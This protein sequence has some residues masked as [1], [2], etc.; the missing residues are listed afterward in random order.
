VCEPYVTRRSV[1][2]F[3]AREP[4]VYFFFSNRNY[5]N[6]VT[7]RPFEPLRGRLPPRTCR[8]RVQTI[9]SSVGGYD[10]CSGSCL[11]DSVS[12]PSRNVV[13]HDDEIAFIL[14]SR[15]DLDLTDVSMCLDDRQSFP[16]VFATERSNVATTRHY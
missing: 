12:R 16:N 3:F 9:P 4:F 10:D 15:C 5:D 8:P 13:L 7:R 6:T 11:P 1:C 2:I 14:T